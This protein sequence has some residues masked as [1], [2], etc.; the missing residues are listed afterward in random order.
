MG[1]YLYSHSDSL[2]FLRSGWKARLSETLLLLLLLQT[3]LPLLWWLL[4]LPLLWLDVVRKV[5]LICNVVNRDRSHM[6]STLGME[7][8]LGVKVS[9]VTKT[10][11]DFGIV[12]GFL[13]VH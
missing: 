12:V 1:P 4:L 10:L 5:T 11:G 9:K 8:C 13:K 2:R 7:R 6:T 3:P